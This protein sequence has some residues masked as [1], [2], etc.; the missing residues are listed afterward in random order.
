MIGAYDL[1]AGTLYYLGAIGTAHQYVMRGL[2]LWRSGNVQSLA[3]GGELE[4]GAVVCLGLGA[5]CEWHLGKIASSQALMNEAISLAK[6]L[7]DMSALALALQWT[8]NLAYYERNPADVERLASDL[9]ELSKRLSFAHWLIHGTILRGW[10]RSAS[11]D[12]TQ[13]I[14]WIDDNSSDS[15]LE[16]TI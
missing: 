15:C 11:G 6:A 2:Q 9:I 4:S 7:N 1:L 5:I 16:N 12:T 13:G 8:T 14:A 10:A 3:C